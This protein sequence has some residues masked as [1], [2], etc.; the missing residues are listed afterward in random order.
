MTANNPFSIRAYSRDTQSHFHEFHQLVL[1]LRG[2]I[3]I[4]VESFDGLVSV[5]DC[6]IIRSGQRHDFS[7]DEKAKFM[8]I[9]SDTLPDNL[10]LS[11]NQKFM[12]DAPLLSYIQFIEKQLNATIHTTTE[13]KM[14]ALFFELLSQQSLS[15][16]RDKRIE[17]VIAKIT[18]DL[19]LPHTNIALAKQACLSVTQFKKVF[20]TSSG[21]T[22]QQYLTQL[23]MEKAK[24]LLTHTDTPI[25]IV[26]EKVGYQSPSAFSRKFKQHFA[27]SPKDLSV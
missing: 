5:G 18:Q 22:P 10:L 12:L 8:V 20:K 14:L 27:T 6:V 23:R 25:N 26:A 16:I 9:D 1:P 21:K 17:K 24:A 4:K 13:T 11:A 7:A 15:V 2:S 3:K 19:S